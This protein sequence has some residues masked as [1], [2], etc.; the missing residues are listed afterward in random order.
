MKLSNLMDPRLVQ[1]NAD[2]TS[3]DAA[4]E[5]ALKHITELYSHEVSYDEAYTR[6]MERQALGGTVF[7]SGIAIPHTRLPDFKDFIIAAIVPRKPFLAP[8]GN[9]GENAPETLIRIVFVV[10]LSQASSAVY[11]NTLA[12]LLSASKDEAIMA[13]LLKAENAAHFVGVF[14]K[15]AYEV[16]K[17][18]LVADVMNKTVVSIRSDETLKTLTDLMFTHHLRY[19]PVVDAK[20]HL[21]GEIGILDLIKAG[22]PD[23]AFRVG[24]LKFLS[25]LEPMTELLLNEEKI[26]ASSIMQKPATPI[27]SKTSVVEAAFEMAKSKKRHF[28]VVDEGRLVGVIS[29]MD[30]LNKVLRA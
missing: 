6:I 29:S 26:P 9:D 7:P 15:A 25:E 4:I 13:A 24:S 19:I 23:Y 5:N 3:V 21:V 22:I 11:L 16:K 10:L 20:E 17:D 8:S 1:L 14:E 28:A 12:K 2:V 30:I 27:D 18:L